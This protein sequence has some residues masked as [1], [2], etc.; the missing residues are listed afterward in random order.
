MDIEIHK[1]STQK[2]A[3]DEI[4]KPFKYDPDYLISSHGTVKSISNKMLC[5]RLGGYKRKYL[6]IG[7]KNKDYY[8]HRMVLE[9]FYGPCPTGYQC[10]HL[11]GNPKNNNINNLKW[12]T[13]KENSFHKILHGTSGKGQFNSMAKIT[14]EEWKEILISY[15]NGMSS[16][17]LA[18]KFNLSGS[19]I[20][21]I[22]TGKIRFNENFIEIYT[23]NK[24]IAKKWIA[25]SNE[26]KRS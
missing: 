4:W 15:S 16:K 11:D 6:R 19:S 5:F 18:T 10:A 13:P 14:D 21:G 7:I 8:V 20:T 24:I 12:V 26:R 22:V 25:T 9:H 2:Q 1:I 3:S 23:K 17:E